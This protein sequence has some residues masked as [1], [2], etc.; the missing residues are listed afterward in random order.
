MAMSAAGCGAFSAL[1]GF[2]GGVEPDASTDDGIDGG[3]DKEAS[4][5]N[6]ASTS[7]DADA[8]AE[9]GDVSVDAGPCAA[10]GLTTRI[11]DSFERSIGLATAS[12]PENWSNF[13]DVAFVSDNGVQVASFAAGGDGG[14]NDSFFAFQAGDVRRV[15]IR[16]RFRIL[17]APASSTRQMLLAKWTNGGTIA[18]VN[19]AIAAGSALVMNEQIISGPGANHAMKVVTMGWH[20]FTFDVDLAQDRARFTIDGVDQLPPGETFPHL[21]SFPPTGNVS[22]AIGARYSASTPLTEIQ[23]DDVLLATATQ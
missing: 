12:S 21:P 6:D 14:T 23:F 19:V 7:S 20:G 22:L 11:C 10:P 9:D 18:Q 1:D 8:G 2:S 13:G 17:T 16:G 4:P 15:T 3:G 5:P